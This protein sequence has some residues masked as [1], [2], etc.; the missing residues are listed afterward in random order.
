[1]YYFIYIMKH[2]FFHC[3]MRIYITFTLFRSNQIWFE[4]YESRISSGSEFSSYKIELR[5]QVTSHFQLLTQ[6]IFTEILFS[7]YL[8][9]FVKH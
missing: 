7:K 5:N 1:M 6:K 3:A 8:L 9:E 4:K 2:T